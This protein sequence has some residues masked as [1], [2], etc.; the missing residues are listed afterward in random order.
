MTEHAP[1]L[2]PPNAPRTADGAWVST[3]TG[4]RACATCGFN[5]LGQPIVREEK[6]GLFIARCPE[7][8]TVAALQ[9]Y[10][11]M[12]RW[13]RRIGALAAALWLLIVIAGSFA[14]GGALLGF[15]MLSVGLG[16]E[17]L[18]SEIEAAYRRHVDAQTATNNPNMGYY[19]GVTEQWWN[20]A[21]KAALLAQSGGV[22][23]ALRR[24]SVA[25]PV[26]AGPAFGFGCVIAVAMMHRRG[27]R[28]ALAATV[29][30]VIAT[31][32]VLMALLADPTNVGVVWSGDLARRI[33]SPYLAP[34]SLATA[35]LG[36]VVGSQVGR[37]IARW[38]A[39]LMLPPRLVTP[40]SS[41]WLCDGKRPPRPDGR[42]PASA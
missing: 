3:I 9:E 24:L 12:G 31:S 27:W 7:C 1:T 37:P 34:I 2:P 11:S 6:Y 33:L 23:A 10:P 22:P 18:G 29:P 20:Q 19:G 15:T 36:L 26:I 25:L 13:A 5:L 14:M 38:L 8:S 40:L 41:L 16:T 4:D 30:W 42:R 21:D 39:R 28:L 32:F 35:W 17:A